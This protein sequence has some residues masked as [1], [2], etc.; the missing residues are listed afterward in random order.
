[1][2]NIGLFLTKLMDAQI[3]VLIPI[4]GL[5][6][7]ML[8][9]PASVMNYLGLD[10]FVAKYKQWISLLLLYSLCCLA[11]KCIEKISQYICRYLRSKRIRKDIKAALLSLSSEEREI[12]NYLY[13]ISKGGD[14]LPFD[15]ASV[16]SLCSRNIIFFPLKNTMIRAEKNYQNCVICMLQPE[17]RKLLDNEPNSGNQK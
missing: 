17:V 14:W 8:F 1:M 16:Q 15:S 4:A 11:W 5:T 13:L 7:F 2:E 3:P 9:V 10:P 6:S 12:V